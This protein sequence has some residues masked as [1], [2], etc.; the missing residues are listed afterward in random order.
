MI[1]AQ[2]KIPL[3]TSLRLEV[4]TGVAGID[5]LAG[6][7]QRLASALPAR[8]YLHLPEWHRAFVSTLVPDPDTVCYAAVYEAGRCRAIVPLMRRPTV[9]AGI[10]LT[11]LALPTH[12][13]MSHTDLVIDPE[14]AGR[15]SLAWLTRQLAAQLPSF[16]VLELDP[17]LVDSGAE[18]LIRAQR[19]ALLLTEPSVH[20]DALPTTSYEALLENLSKNFKGNLRKARNKL[21]KCGA[22]AR[23]V[24]ATT[25][26][27]LG[28][29]FESFLAVE[30]SGWKGQEG[31]AIGLDPALR[32]FYQQL[33]QRLGAAGTCAIN[34][35]VLDDKPIAAQ[36]AIVGGD[37]YFLLKIG[38]DESQAALAPGNLLLEW[39]LKKYDGHPVLRHIDLV[40][41]A[42]WHGSWKPE[43]RSLQRHLL[44]RP[45]TRGLLAWTA[46][47][48]RPPLRRLRIGLR[49]GWRNVVAAV[50]GLPFG[51][52]F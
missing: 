19:P 37:R 16:D 23:M 29:A 32:S 43:A 4:L 52:G 27:E 33:V 47:Q 17:V 5:R 1:E 14:F 46:W 9:V 38:Y 44:L 7:W 36:F 25:L 12:E 42:A 18:A 48:G 13:H 31:T 3:E 35:L 22:R 20:S 50:R 6:D 51:T 30:A 2:G 24:S 41:D 45:T 39:L 49:S 21:E 11:A 34:L 10:P 40:S 26:E 15:L 8:S 28:P